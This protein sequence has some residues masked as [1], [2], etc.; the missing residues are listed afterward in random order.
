MIYIDY[1]KMWAVIRKQECE[2][3][4]L[5]NERDELFNMTQPKG[6]TFDKELVDSSHHGNT[7]ET[8]A[9]KEEYLTNK[10]HQL[11]QSIT[12]RYQLLNRKRKE[13]EI[14]KNIYDRIYYL[15]FIEKLSIYKIAN[16]VG[17]ERT[18]IW[19]HLK[20]IEKNIT[21]NILQH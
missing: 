5:I 15:K 16:L 8:Y 18:S 9:I 10:I 6:T 20:K 21:C 14:S 4:E 3:I 19:R 2:L 1:E 13:L 11:D 17:Y 12:D 7:L